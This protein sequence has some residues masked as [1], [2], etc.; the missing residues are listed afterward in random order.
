MGW[1]T[2]LFRANW[3]PYAAI[4]LTVVVTTATGFGYMKGYASAKNDMQEAINKS[5][6]T[7]MKVNQKLTKK[8]LKTFEELKD[9]EQGVEDAINNIELPEIDPACSAAFVGWMRAF[10]DAVRTSAANTEATN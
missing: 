5:L 8:D 6:K 3:F 7:Q 4:G 10:N 2:A 1:L 9:A